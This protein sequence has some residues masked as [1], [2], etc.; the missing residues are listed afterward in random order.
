MNRDFIELLAAFNAHAVEYLVV[1]AHALAAH[2]YVRA[3]KDL[4]IWVRPSEENA[5]KVLAALVEFGA[6]LHDLTSEDL[7]T[8]GTV[9]QIGVPPV[10]IDVLTQIDG[11]VFE[12]A[13]PDHVDVNLGDTSVPILSRHHLIANKKASGRLQDLAD[14]E[15]LEEIEGQEQ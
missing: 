13:W 14:V 10:R 11:V 7:A 1:G 15:R 5:P 3:T 9:F 2:G 12:L 8:G 6:P 4:D